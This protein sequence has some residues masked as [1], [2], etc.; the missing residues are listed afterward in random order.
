MILVIL[1]ILIFQIILIILIIP[2]LLISR[3]DCPESG[4]GSDSRI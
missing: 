2:T 1:T 4:R 3:P